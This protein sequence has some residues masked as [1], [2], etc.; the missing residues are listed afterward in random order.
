MSQSSFFQFKR[1]GTR[2]GLGFAVVL[3]MTLA[4]ALAA[5]W[6]L[7]RIHQQNDEMDRSAQHLSMAQQWSG[8]VQ[9]NL[10]RAMT[11]TRLEA[12]VSD[13]EALRASADAVVSRLNQDMAAGAGQANQLQERLLANVQDGTL[14]QMIEAVNANRDKFVKLRAAIRDDLQ[15]G[16]GAERI[17]KELA[18]SATFMLTSL[19]NL[20]Q[21][22]ESSSSANSQGL[23]NRVQLAQWVVLALGAA[24]LLLGAVIAILTTRALSKPLAYSAGVA[25]QIAAGRLSTE[26]RVSGQDENAQLLAAMR[27]MRDQLATMVS[28]VRDSA[29]GLVST[30]DR[31]ASDSQALADRT[32][33]QAQVLQETALSVSEL[34]ASAVQN[35]QNARAARDQVEQAG[36]VAQRSGEVVTQAVESIQRINESSRQ[37]GEIVSVIDG[38]AFQT[39]ILALNAAV[40]AARAGEAGRGFAVVASEVRALAQRSGEAAKEIRGLIQR[41]VDGMATGNALVQQSGE[42]MQEVLGAVRR[43]SGMMLE[44]GQASETQSSGVSRISQVVGELDQGTQHNASLVDQSAQV[45]R[46]LQAQAEQLLALVARFDTGSV[47]ASVSPAVTRTLPPLA[48]Q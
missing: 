35:A 18:D 40:E 2:L 38:I 17:D 29:S 46:Q 32:Q 6:Q 26:V 3:A 31:L 10:E 14:R 22:L 41:S 36:E 42:R 1:I 43:V 44:V 27:D 20:R 13:N 9:T 8:I 24:T 5:T 23:R 37:I 12:L 48:R 11:A 15:L 16:E 21:Y 47:S 33:Q 34:D 28:Q 30:S 4:M 7:W 25:R 39:N 19:D 45:A